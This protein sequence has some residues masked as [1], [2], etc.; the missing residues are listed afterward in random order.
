M[1]PTQLAVA[2]FCL[3]NWSICSYFSNP[4][5]PFRGLKW[6]LAEWEGLLKL[7]ITLII[8][9]Y[10]SIS[11][12]VNEAT[13]LLQCQLGVAC[14]RASIMEWPSWYFST[15]AAPCLLSLL[16]SAAVEMYKQPA[17]RRMFLHQRAWTVAGFTILLCTTLLKFQITRSTD[18]FNYQAI[19]EHVQFSLILFW[20]LNWV[21][22]SSKN[23]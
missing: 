13:S 18:Y 6:L 23:L 4:P 1:S 11:Q 9:Q 3:A 15:S 22:F 19:M 2:T 8:L 20:S 16:H 17:R 7:V 21:F 14:I 5:K 12:P 10:Q